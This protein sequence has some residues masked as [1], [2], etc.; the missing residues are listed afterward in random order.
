MGIRKISRERTQRAQRVEHEE[1]ERTETGEETV[2]TVEHFTVAGTTPLLGKL[3]GFKQGVNE[4]RNA[5]SSGPVQLEI[6]K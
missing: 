6:E 2:E 1:T 4:S 5:V 3:S